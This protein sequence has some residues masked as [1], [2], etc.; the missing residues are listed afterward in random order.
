MKEV[1]PYFATWRE[2]ITSKEK[3][4]H[5]K[6]LRRNGLFASPSHAKPKRA[7]ENRSKTIGMAPRTF[8]AACR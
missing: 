3:Q 6:A 7:K 2:G 4:F 8:N 1:E 5:A